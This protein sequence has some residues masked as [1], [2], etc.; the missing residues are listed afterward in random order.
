MISPIRQKLR[1]DLEA[2]PSQ[3]MFGSG[4][5]SGVIALIT[6]LACLAIALCMQF[7][8]FLTV[9]QLQEFYSK[10]PFRIFLYILLLT[11]YLMALISLI[12]RSTK[13]IGISSLIITLL[14]TVIC[15]FNSNSSQIVLFNGAF[16]GLDWFILNIIFTGLLF[17]PLENLWPQNKSQGLFRAEWREDLFYYLIS[18]LLVQI[19]TYLSLWP[20]QFI[21]GQTNWENIRSAI[22]NQ[23]FIFQLLEIMFLTDLVQYW[24]H[25][26][27][28]KI[29]ALWNFHAVHHSAKS[30][31]WMAGARMHF[32]EIVVLRAFT[33]LPMQLL[34]FETAP[35]QTYILIV[36]IYSTLI[37]AN[38]SWSPTWLTNILVTPRFHHWHH[39][40]EREAIDVNFSIHFPILDR[41]FGTFHMPS[42]RWPKGYG[43]KQEMPIG[44][45]RQFLFPF[46]KKKN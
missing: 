45:W 12:L 11:T 37:H 18:S 17:I 6:S 26:S 21:L 1:T 36:Y 27:F 15:S 22:A 43:I 39:G 41:L 44:Y 29:P 14:A 2:P 28:H 33:V 34:G 35:I 10:I 16:L 19:F 3:R 9:P 40:I 8:N 38:I 7:P 5:I 30:M 31:D 42:N 13:I 24:V 20:S 25:R 4:W 32:I 23:A 46:M